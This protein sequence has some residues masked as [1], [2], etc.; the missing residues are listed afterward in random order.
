[1][2]GG[3][4]GLALLGVM[5]FALAEAPPSG[6]GDLAPV[7]WMSGSWAGTHGDMQMEELWMAPRG[8]AMLGLHRDVRGG[9]MVSFEYSRIEAT[10]QGIVY[11]ASPGGSAPTPFGLTES[12][13]KRVVFENAIHD[14]PQRIIYWLGSDGAL[15]A[16]IEGIVE[17]KLASEEWT[18]MR[19]RPGAR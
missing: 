14:F 19:V 15:H 4:A 1:M 12:K 18:W 8:G 9:K 3:T 17:G 6:G 16:R 13:G 2:L 7:A 10:P 5:T 11:F